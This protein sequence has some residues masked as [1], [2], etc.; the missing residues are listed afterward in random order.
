MDTPDMLRRVDYGAWV[1]KSGEHPGW[2]KDGRN[3]RQLPREEKVLM[4]N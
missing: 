3:L 4:E 2:T 1:F